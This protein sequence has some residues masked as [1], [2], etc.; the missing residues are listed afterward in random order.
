MAQ[1]VDLTKI[2][3]LVIV[4]RDKF[5][6]FGLLAQVFASEPHVRLVWDRRLRERRHDSASADPADRRRRDRRRVPSTTWGSNDYLLVN[7]AGGIAPDVAPTTDIA[8]A[9]HADQ[10]AVDSEEI[11][12]DIE[13]AVKSDLTVLISGGD[14]TS[15]KSVAQRIHGRSD[16]NAGSLLVVDRDAFLVGESVETDLPRAAP[17]EWTTAG[18]I[19]IEEV[20]DLSWEQQSQL[21]RI[22][23]WPVVQ[24]WDRRAN[25]S[26]DARLITGTRYHLLDL[27]A[28]RQFRADLFYR[29]N[30]IHIVLPSDWVSTPD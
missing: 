29:L 18:T 22:L 2:Q 8:S 12:R 4:K 6:T 15:R 9:A 7:I 21:V 26:R 27:V 11:R 10:R 13:A 28:A 1:T 20:A 3:P 17:A 14:A 30:V 19:L 24:G 5:A 23:E 16:R 25:P